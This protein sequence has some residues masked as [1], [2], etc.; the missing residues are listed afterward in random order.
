[1]NLCHRAEIRSHRTPHKGL[2]YHYALLVGMHINITFSKKI[3]LKFK[4]GE[5]IW[6]L[7]TTLLCRDVVKNKM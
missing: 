6:Q 5:V 1:M 4:C 7:F 2:A 3:W